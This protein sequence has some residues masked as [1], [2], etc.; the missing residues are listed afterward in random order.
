MIYVNKH[1]MLHDF[2]HADIAEK[3]ISQ[4]PGF[5]SGADNMGNTPLHLACRHGLLGTIRLLLQINGMVVYRKS[6][7]NGRFPNHEAA[8]EGRIEVYRE[9]VERFSDRRFVRH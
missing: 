2:L 4:V 5:A 7:V 6:N 1:G 3:R 9:L 8:I